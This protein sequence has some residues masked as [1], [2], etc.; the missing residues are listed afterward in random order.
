MPDFFE[1]ADC[2]VAIAGDRGNTVPKRRVTAGEIAVLQVIHGNDAVLEV[3]PLGKIVRSQRTER[4]R[5][6]ALYGGARDNNGNS[7][8]EKLYPG[9]AARIFERLEELVLVDEQFAAERKGLGGSERQAAAL[10]ASQK[11]IDLSIV[12]ES[13]IIP[14]GEGEGQRPATSAGGDYGNE[15]DGGE[16]LDD[17]PADT[18]FSNEQ[19]A[20]DQTAGAD[21]LS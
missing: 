13:E 15:G 14:F 17:L 20:A 18:G 9:A 8:L 4:E 19:P 6:K 10:E 7:L 16:D 3:K 1:V 11:G 5:L 21:A 2:L 12:D